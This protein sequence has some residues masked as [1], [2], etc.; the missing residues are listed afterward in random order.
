[1]SRFNRVALR[2]AVVALAGFSAVGLAAGAASAKS[3]I[4][5]S[6][7][8]RTVHVGGQIHLK[9][10]G[11]NDDFHIKRFCVQE[12]TGHHAWRDLKCTKPGIGG[13][14]S[15][16]LRVKATHRGTYQFRGVL[17]EKS[18]GNRF[19]PGPTS[20]VRTVTVR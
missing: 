12:R 8:P 7:G 2:T 6:A 20:A 13:G 16:T 18:H 4:S 19:E 11:D 14:G 15:L 17:F 5:L 1:M 3:D 9:G 10:T